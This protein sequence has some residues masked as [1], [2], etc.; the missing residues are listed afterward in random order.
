M[1]TS[2][3]KEDQREQQLASVEE[4]AKRLIKE[5]GTR[6]E[7]NLETAKYLD[8]EAKKFKKTTKKAPWYH[9]LWKAFT[10]AISQFIKNTSRQRP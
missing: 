5:L 8:K 4:K 2:P 1:T 7:A 6:H 10:E 3:E 9:R